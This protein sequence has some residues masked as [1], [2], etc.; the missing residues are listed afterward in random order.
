M[1][2]RKVYLDSS[3]GIAAALQEADLLRELDQQDEAVVAYRRALGAIPEGVEFSNPWIPA[4]QYRNRILEA[5]RHYLDANDFDRAIAIAEKLSPLFTQARQAQVLAET[6]RTRA[7]KVLADATALRGPEGNEA[8]HQGRALWRKAGRLYAE[9]AAIN[10]TARDYADDLWQAAEAYLQGH[11]FK[12]AAIAFEDYLKHELRR[13]RPRALTGLAEA[14]LALND[15]EGTLTACEECAEFYPQDAANYRARLL[16]A[17]A[18]LERGE[19]ATAESLLRKNL[20]SDLL[21]PESREWRDSLFSLGKVLHADGRYD[22]AIS[23]LQEFVSRYPDTPQAVEGRYLIAE[24]YRE[25]AKVPQ[26]KLETDTIE[27]ARVA[28]QKQKNQYLAGA[29]ENYEQVQAVLNRQAEQRELTVQEKSILRNSYFALGSAQFDLGRYEDALQTY[30]TASN[31]YQH[32]PEVLEAF[33]QMASC[34]RRLNRPIEARG[35]LQQAKVVLDRLPKDTNF[36]A[37]TNCNRREWGEM[38]DWLGTL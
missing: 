28:H 23:R 11:D 17:Q 4:D 2:T 16:A 13:R 6:Y 38:L 26:K 7:I 10:F 15:L 33:V 19:L 37:M 35:T 27:T 1:R 25:A 21:T 3:E 5:Y 8:I 14:R 34:L 32:D 22:E 9:L 18:N 30:S 29:I 36:T 20:T 12:H 31:R 24:A